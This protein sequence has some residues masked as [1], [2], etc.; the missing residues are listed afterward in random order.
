MYGNNVRRLK[1]KKK[2]I[3]IGCFTVIATACIV[4]LILLLGVGKPDEQSVHEPSPVIDPDH[5]EEAAVSDLDDVSRSGIPQETCAPQTTSA[6]EECLPS[7][8][9]D[10]E[11]YTRL[12]ITDHVQIELDQLPMSEY[13]QMP[14]LTAE[15]ISIPTGSLCAAFSC[16]EKTDNPIPI[17]ISDDGAKLTITEPPWMYIYKTPA[18]DRY[19]FFLPI[20]DELNDM[21][22]YF[23][24][25]TDLESFSRE[26]ALMQVCAILSGLGISTAPNPRIITLD[27]Q[28]LNSAQAALEKSLFFEVET[29]GN[30]KKYART[31]TKDDE[32]Y[33][34]VFEQSLGGYPID[35]Y[36]CR[37][38][39]DQTRVYSEVTALIGRKGLIGM[40]ISGLYSIMGKEAEKPVIGYQEAVDSLTDYFTE[41]VSERDLC[42][43]RAELKLVAVEQKR[44]IVLKPMWV[45][46]STDG[47]A[48]LDEIR[49]R[50]FDELLFLTRVYV[51]AYSGEVIIK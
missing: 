50:N 43:V 7:A 17:Y 14:T 37:G 35:T 20:D 44:K 38:V 6:K 36:F 4:A 28:S 18:Y 19:S 3:L 1:R 12:T 21:S 42:F 24:S 25:E 30:R 27:T 11:A 5:S 47:G 46:T 23:A 41:N 32:C 33:A 13:E 8:S 49:N 9:L 48:G 15:Y 29:D 34:L 22:N 31:W 45:F 40:E 39:M 16:Y 10:V 26:D 2:R 51:D